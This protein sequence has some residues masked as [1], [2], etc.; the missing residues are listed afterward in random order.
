MYHF[1]KPF[2]HNVCFDYTDRCLPFL[3]LTW[4]PCGWCLI[5]GGLCV[6]CVSGGP[7]AMPSSLNCRCFTSAELQHT[8]PLIYCTHQ[9][10]CLLLWE[11]SSG[12]NGIYFDTLH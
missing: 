9:T 10:L 12:S 6:S 8:T 5:D 1:Q 3:A 7:V 11:P 2:V 4:T